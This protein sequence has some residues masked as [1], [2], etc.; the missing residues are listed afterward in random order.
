MAR[1]AA[2]VLCTRKHITTSTIA[3]RECRRIESTGNRISRDE[4]GQCGSR[5]VVF[6]RMDV[7]QNL[8]PN[9]CKVGAI[10]GIGIPYLGRTLES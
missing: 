4:M 7:A 8:V 5:G 1:T 9:F 3:V 6:A 10:R 2:H